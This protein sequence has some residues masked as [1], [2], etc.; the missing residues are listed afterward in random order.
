MAQLSQTLVVLLIEY[1]V[2][3][4]ILYEI[5]TLKCVLHIYLDI[6]LFVFIITGNL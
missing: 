3:A 2:M 5:N 6:E 4:I 1:D